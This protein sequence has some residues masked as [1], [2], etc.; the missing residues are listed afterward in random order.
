[1]SGLA[2]T[3]HVR[4]MTCGDHSLPSQ[5]LTGN[6]EPV[7]LIFL[8]ALRYRFNELLCVQP[9]L[10]LRWSKY[11]FLGTWHLRAVQDTGGEFDV[12]YSIAAH[13]I[14]PAPVRTALTVCNEFELILTRVD[15]Y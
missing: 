7:M 9:S 8:Q 11:G 5:Y 13:V 1:M 6:H 10:N 2:I 14:E 12:G 15:D 4:S 3:N